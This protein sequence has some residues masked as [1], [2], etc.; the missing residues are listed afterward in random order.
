MHPDA[1]PMSSLTGHD[2][3]NVM[4]DSHQ[5]ADGLAGPVSVPSSLLQMLVRPVAPVLDYRTAVTGLTAADLQV[6]CAQPDLQS[7]AAQCSLLW[8]G[9]RRCTLC[10]HA[11]QAS[12]LPG[13]GLGCL[14]SCSPCRRALFPAD[15]PSLLQGVAFRHADAQRAVVQLMAQPNAVLVGHS[16]HHDLQALKIG[17]T[18]AS[19]LCIDTSF[20]WGY[21]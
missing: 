21:R 3:A 6:G 8:P 7:L 2:R 18:P 10:W 12:T 15:L 19:L 9:S 20:L 1:A 13:D 14:R 4:P 5:R 11:G 16:L 17:V